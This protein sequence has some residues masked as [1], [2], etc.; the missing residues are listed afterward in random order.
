MDELLQST[1]SVGL[2]G[3]KPE[4]VEKVEELILNTLDKVVAEGFSDEAIASSMNTIE[5][6]VSHLVEFWACWLSQFFSR[7]FFLSCANSIPV[8]SL[9]D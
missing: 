5:F 6:Q 3:I 7:L 1:F 8:L 9:R 2:K 4:N